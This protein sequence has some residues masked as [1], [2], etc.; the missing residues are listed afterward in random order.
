[1]E[2]AG[3][4]SPGELPAHVEEQGLRVVRILA[5]AKMHPD[6]LS[7]APIERSIRRHDYI[8]SATLHLTPKLRPLQPKFVIW[9]AKYPQLHR[10]HV[11]CNSN[12]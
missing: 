11:Y 1:M 10:Q 3:G 4:Q 2:C 9:A 5:C 8:A 6:Q 7:A 12:D